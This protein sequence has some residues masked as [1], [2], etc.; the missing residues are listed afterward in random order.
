LSAERLCAISEYSGAWKAAKFLW[1]DYR[2][3][4]QN[5]LS[6]PTANQLLSLMIKS[7]LT[8]CLTRNLITMTH[9]DW[10]PRNRQDLYNQANMTKDYLNAS[11][12]ERIGITGNAINWDNTEVIPKLNA[13]NL[14]FENWKDSAEKYLL[15][16]TR[17]NF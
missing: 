5:K 14:V 9:N 8:E 12:L 3:I 17:N 6:V 13:F 10:L 1:Y 15:P 4:P 11:N 16:Y 2:D 7:N